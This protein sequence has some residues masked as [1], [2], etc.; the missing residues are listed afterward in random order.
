MAVK[1]ALSTNAWTSKPRKKRPVYTLR[2]SVVSP[3]RAETGQNL[4]EGKVDSWSKQK[5]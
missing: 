4:I 2:L 3:R 5:D 1:K